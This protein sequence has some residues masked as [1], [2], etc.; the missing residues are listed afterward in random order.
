M[1]NSTGKRIDWDAVKGRL[2]TAQRMHEHSS[3]VDE[4]NMRKLFQK[5]AE[6][7]A[8]TGTRDRTKAPTS[9]VLVFR[10]NNER[11]GVELR[12]LAQVFPSI[13]ITPVPGAREHILGIANLQGEIRTVFGLRPLLMLAHNANEVARYILLLR[14]N[15]RRIG[16]Q[17]EHV[18]SVQQLVLDDLCEHA[19]SSGDMRSGYVRCVTSEKVIVL[20]TDKVFESH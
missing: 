10:L 16:L 5:R 3:F 17:V 8:A 15:E 11:Y 18:E 6:R 20:D 4:D 12:H 9:S 14:Q 7:L 2:L 13:R 19:F 1:K